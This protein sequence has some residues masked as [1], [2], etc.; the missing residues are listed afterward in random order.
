MVELRAVDP[1]PT[2]AEHAAPPGARLRPEAGVGS[3]RL[4]PQTRLLE[5]NPTHGAAM[6]SN[7]PIGGLLRPAGFEDRG[8]V[9]G[10]FAW[11]GGLPSIRG[12]CAALSRGLSW[13]SARMRC[14]APVSID[15][16][17][18]REVFRREHTTRERV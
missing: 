5:P 14:S 7:H 13:D 15:Y 2:S 12:W 4:G 1:R 11:E 16:E 10:Y 18:Q 3:N 8:G 17:Q 9:S 6:E